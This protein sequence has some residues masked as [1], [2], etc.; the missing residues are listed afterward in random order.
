[1][2]L[3]WSISKKDTNKS[4][5]GH[6][7]IGKRKSIFYLEKGLSGGVS[8]NC[9]HGLDLHLPVCSYINKFICG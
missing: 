9:Q 3:E 5:Y 4:I 7:L 8:G 1:M 6:I 2:C